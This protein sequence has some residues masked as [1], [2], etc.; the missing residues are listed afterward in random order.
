MAVDQG[1]P[2]AVDASLRA[3]ERPKHLSVSRETIA[4]LQAPTGL[5]QGR[6]T[7]QLRLLNGGLGVLGAD[8]V[9]SHPLSQGLGLI[10]ELLQHLPKVDGA[11]RVIITQGLSADRSTRQHSPDDDEHEAGEGHTTDQTS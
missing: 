5:N 8:A 7:L 2:S 1:G 9:V 6:K 4:R 11:R 10:E 3:A